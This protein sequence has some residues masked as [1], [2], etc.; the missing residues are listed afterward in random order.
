MGFAKMP[1]DE[2]IRFRKLMEFSY[3]GLSLLNESLE[4]IYRGPSFERIMGWSNEEL[5][6]L[7]I[8]D[9]IHYEDL[10]VVNKS[11]QEIL[12]LS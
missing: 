3:E 8:S 6:A 2:D 9:L 12:T 7:V 10:E 4:S 1:L 5:S 11:F